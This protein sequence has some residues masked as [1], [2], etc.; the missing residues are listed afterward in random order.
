M[1]RCT[2]RVVRIGRWICVDG[3]RPVVNFLIR[4]LTSKWIRL[5]K[6]YLLLVQH[7]KV[8]LLLLSIKGLRSFAYCGFISAPVILLKSIHPCHLQSSLDYHDVLMHFIR[9][10]YLD[11]QHVVT[12]KTIYSIFLIKKKQ[13]N[14]LLFKYFLQD[15][16][17]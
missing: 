7:E 15:K 4:W 9:I 12:T 3:K 16:S 13:E 1:L 10:G 5:I 11:W 6:I 14:W 8:N 2:P 17:E